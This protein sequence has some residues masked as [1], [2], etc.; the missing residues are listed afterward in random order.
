LLE[1]S[2]IRDQALQMLQDNPEQLEKVMNNPKLMELLEKFQTS[3][4]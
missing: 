2:E 4:P 3:A 1:N